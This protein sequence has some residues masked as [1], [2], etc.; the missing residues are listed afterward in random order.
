[1]Q[2]AESLWSKCAMLCEL[3]AFI[4]RDWCNEWQSF[5]VYIDT[6]RLHNLI[7]LSGIGKI[8]KFNQLIRMG[9]WLYPLFTILLLNRK[10]CYIR[11]RESKWTATWSSSSVP[12]DWC[13]NNFQ[14]IGNSL[15]TEAADHLRWLPWFP[16]NHNRSSKSCKVKKIHSLKN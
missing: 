10:T 12:D 13:R 9:N 15:H 11:E 6:A 16:F 2:W 8:W 4:T 3:S 1:M 7:F 14:N 5:V